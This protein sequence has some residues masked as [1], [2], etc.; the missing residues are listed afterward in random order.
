MIVL[1]SITDVNKLFLPLLVSYSTIIV[2]GHRWQPINF[3]LAW[4]AGAWQTEEHNY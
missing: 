3:A 1:Q 2:A 4:W